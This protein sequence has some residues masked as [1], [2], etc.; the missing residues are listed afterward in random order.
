M[1]RLALY[2]FLKVRVDCNSLDLGA[3]LFHMTLLLNIGAL[4]NF[5]FIGYGTFSSVAVPRL[6]TLFVWSI[7]RSFSARLC[8]SVIRCRFLLSIGV[9]IS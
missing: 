9:S 5:F 7:Y 1:T 8:I 3:R 6:V 2:A 4:A